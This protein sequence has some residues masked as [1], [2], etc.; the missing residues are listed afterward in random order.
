MRQVNMHEAKS[1]LSRLVESVIN[2]EEVVIARNGQPVA[3]LVP[4]TTAAAPRVFGHAL[5]Q[6]SI[7]DDFD[8]LPAEPE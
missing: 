5:G 4:F 3:R 7:A 8:E 6:I 2:G 1:Q